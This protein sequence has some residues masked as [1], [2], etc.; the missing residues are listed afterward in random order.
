MSHPAVD[1]IRQIVGGLPLQDIL[2][3]GDV[4]EGERKRR[5]S[6]HPPSLLAGSRV[7]FWYGGKYHQGEILRR[8]KLF[9]V[10]VDGGGRWSMP[11]AYLILLEE[12]S[13]V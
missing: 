8:G 2:E 12:V 3:L 10:A 7:G 4:L 1:H 11:P 13:S 6:A 5:Y 9:S